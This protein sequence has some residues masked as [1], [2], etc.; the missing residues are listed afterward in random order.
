MTLLRHLEGITLQSTGVARQAVVAT[1]KSWLGYALLYLA[2]S[3]PLAAHAADADIEQKAQACAACH[4]PHGQSSIATTPS[5]AGQ[6][7]RYL[8]EELRDFKAGRRDSPTMTPIA[9]TLSAGD[10]QAFADYFSAQRP[11]SSNAAT[12][13]ATVAQGRSIATSA[14]CTMCHAGDLTGQ[15]EVPRVAGQQQA[16]VAKQLENFRD[17]HRTNDGGTMQAVAHGITDPQIEALA[18]YVSSLQ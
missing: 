14:L 5:L 11:M 1:S 4:G 16:Y 13:A 10:M 12:D 8:F 7:S 17:G 3:A 15:N 18:Q 6:T 2:A 9:T